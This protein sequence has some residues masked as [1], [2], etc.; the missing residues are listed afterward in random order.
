MVVRLFLDQ[1][2][3]SK[4]MIICNIKFPNINKIRHIVGIIILFI[5][6]TY[7]VLGE[8]PNEKMLEAN[9][10]WRLRIEKERD[11]ASCWHDVLCKCF[12]RKIVSSYRKDFTIET[13][14]SLCDYTSLVS[15]KHFL[16]GKIDSASIDKRA[17]EFADVWIKLL[18]KCRVINLDPVLLAEAIYQVSNSDWEP[19][20]C[21]R[22][23]NVK[24]DITDGSR[25]EAFG[26]AYIR[27]A[28]RSIHAKKDYRQIWKLIPLSCQI[29]TPE[30]ID[31]VN[32]FS[33]PKPP[34]W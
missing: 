27:L 25:L 11:K 12:K 26:N 9:R 22:N 6:A 10:E 19:V 15:Y 24:D 7:T 30:E 16:S 8:R 34:K 21:G 20:V 31:K 13:I 29:C 1:A 3:G 4:S 23:M 17:E 18:K 14:N 28:E 32:I 33:P 5:G 2:S